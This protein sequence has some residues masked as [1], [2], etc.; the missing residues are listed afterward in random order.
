MN[1]LNNCP[2]CNHEL[3]FIP[4]GLIENTHICINCGSIFKYKSII[5]IISYGMGILMLFIL[6]SPFRSLI[7]LMV[8]ITI[9]IGLTSLFGYKITGEFVEIDAKSLEE[10]NDEKNE[11]P[12]YEPEKLVYLLSGFIVASIL[13]IIGALVGTSISDDQYVIGKVIGIFNLIGFLYF[14]WMIIYVF[15]A[16]LYFKIKEN[17]IE[18][19]GYIISWISISSLF[20]FVFDGFFQNGYKDII[21]SLFPILIIVAIVSFVIQ[22]LIN[23]KR[24]TY[25]HDGYT[26]K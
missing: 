24:I 25:D 20:L 14:Q 5:N 19:I 9:R 16:R 15:R 4:N 21:D 11:I 2:N 22:Y 1:K 17:F 18:Y 7:G 26:H 10:N 12:N 8:V 3:N 6:D 23:K 13:F